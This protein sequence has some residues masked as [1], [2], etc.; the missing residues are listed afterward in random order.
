MSFTHHKFSRE[1][2][3]EFYN[4]LRKRVN[5]YFE[6]NN[7]PRHGNYKIIIKTVVLALIYLVPYGLMISGVVT[8]TPLFIGLWMVMGFGMA[9]IGLCVMHDA[10]HGSY[11][12]NKTLNNIMAHSMN[13][14]GGTACI[15]KMQHNVLHHTYTNIKGADEDIEAGNLLRFSPVQPKMKMHRFQ[16]IYAWFLYCLMTFMRVTV[17]DFLQ[18]FKFKKIGLVKTQKDFNAL[19]FR[20]IR[21]KIFYY[22]YILVLPMV[23]LPQSPWLILGCFLLMLAVTGLILSVI[24]QTA[25]VMT[26][27]DF[28]T[29]DETGTHAN[30]WAVHQINTTTNYSP[31][32][33]I[34]SW[35]VGGLNYQIEHHLFANISHVHYKKLSPIVSST[36]EEFGVKYNS[37]KTF[38]HAIADHGKMLRHLGRV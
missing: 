36:A 18:L 11:S 4:T 29:P 1:N 14:I 13:L 2:N 22:G 12:N 34:F 38:V 27:C 24:F 20:I 10:N 21:W 32:S 31:K 6:E 5:N 9:T 15:W 28:P 37:H 19:L 33:R 25:H 3:A 8:S 30:S 16:H 35:F 23:L 7:L 26:T 17:K